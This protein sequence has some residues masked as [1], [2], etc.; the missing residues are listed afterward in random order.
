MSVDLKSIIGELLYEYDVVIIPGFGGFV[1]NYKSS[2]IDHVQGLLH[3]PSKSLTFNENLVVNDGILTNYIKNNKGEDLPASKALIKDFVAE[4]KA[5]IDAREIIVFPKVG[6]LY[7]DY[8]NKL[9]FLPDNQNYNLDV[10]G[11]DSVQFYPILR[12]KET[13]VA[14]AIAPK[15]ATMTTIKKEALP[16]RKATVPF[17]QKAMPYLLGLALFAFV[18]TLYTVVKKDPNIISTVQK[19]PVSETRINTKPSLD[20]ADEE[21]DTDVDEKFGTAIAEDEESESDL[22]A[23][24]DITT[25]T[26]ARKKRAKAIDTEASTL[27]P[28][29]KEAI[30]IIGA[31]RSKDNVRKLI[32]K[33]YDVGFDAYQ[34]KKKDV[35]RV[36]AQFFYEKDKDFQKKLKIIRNKFEKKAWVLKH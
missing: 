15:P 20:F 16:K 19:V 14:E 22:I 30:V 12:N 24:A 31:Y 1:A 9:Q 18:I 25:K 26:P 3:P 7:K 29:Q 27:A 5:K 35:T 11:L 4:L 10:F 28:N 21:F 34:D 17:I 32:E 6:R 33:L 13:T 2:H 36:G 8:E 23:E